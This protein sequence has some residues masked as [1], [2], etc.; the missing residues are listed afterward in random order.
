[1]TIQYIDG[2]SMYARIFEHNRDM[3]GYEGKHLAYD[4]KYE[5]MIGVPEN[6]PEY[7]LFMSW[8]KKYEPKVGGRDKNFE[9]DKGAVEG[10][11]YFRVGRKHAPKKKD[12]TLIA[13]W[14]GPPACYKAEVDPKTKKPIPW[15][16]DDLIGNGSDITVKLDIEPDKA[17]PHIK[18]V[19]LEAVMVNNLV[20]FKGKEETPDDILADEI[21]F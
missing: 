10:L 12:G 5:I 21:P 2:K 15:N 16:P 19:R 6:S 18:Y 9:V 3:E 17:K 14:G 11:C 4:G 8:N 20:E 13:A 1:M 7:K